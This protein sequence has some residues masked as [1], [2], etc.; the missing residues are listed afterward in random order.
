MAEIVRNLSF[1]PKKEKTI[2]PEAQ[3]KMWKGMVGGALTADL[4]K[5]SQEEDVF[6]ISSSWSRTAVSILPSPSTVSQVGY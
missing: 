6:S 5:T 1:A 4:V 3:G 2:K